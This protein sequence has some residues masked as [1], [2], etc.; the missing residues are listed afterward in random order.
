MDQL[1]NP[2]V[3]KLPIQIPAI[4]KAKPHHEHSPFSK[5][6]AAS[7]QRAQVMR[8]HRWGNPGQEMEVRKQQTKAQNSKI[9]FLKLS[10]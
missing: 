9:M 1:Q 6:T 2:K 4:C 5:E 10:W 3:I 8:P 7:F